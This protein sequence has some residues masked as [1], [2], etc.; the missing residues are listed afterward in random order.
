MTVEVVGFEMVPGPVE[1]IAEGE[2]SVSHETENGKLEQEPG[3]AEPVKSGSDGNEAAKAEVDGVPDSSG[4]KD[5]TEE[6]PAPQQIHSFYFV[7]FRPY[8]DPD[9]KSKVDKLD[10]EIYL[11]NQARFQITEALKAKRV[12]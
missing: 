11:T 6:W 2:K 9:I 8:D 1:N 10:K 3:A 7:R 12:S 5:A 4:P